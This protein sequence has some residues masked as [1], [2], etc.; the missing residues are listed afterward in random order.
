MSVAVAQRRKFVGGDWIDSSGLR[1]M[2]K[3]D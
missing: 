3:I 2:A 1:V